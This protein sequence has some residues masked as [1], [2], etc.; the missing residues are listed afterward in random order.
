M[1]NRFDG[2]TMASIDLGSCGVD[3]GTVDV[4]VTYS[5][6]DWPQMR[7]ALFTIR[8]DGSVDEGRETLF[9]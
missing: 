3:Q 4:R 8:S 1:R 7:A 2:A 9:P 5:R 6:M